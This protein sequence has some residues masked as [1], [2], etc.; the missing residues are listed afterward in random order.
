MAKW[1][2]AAARRPSLLADEVQQST[3]GTLFWILTNGVVRR[4]HAR[5]VQAA[6]TAALADRELSQVTLS[7]RKVSPVTAGRFCACRPSQA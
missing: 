1:R 6:G 7:R 3:P 5:V 4:W 2:K